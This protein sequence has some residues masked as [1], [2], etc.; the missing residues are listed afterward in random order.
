MQ[1]HIEEAQGPYGE[2]LDVEIVT[3]DSYFQIVILY[4]S[5]ILPFIS[6]SFNYC[7]HQLGCATDTDTDF[8]S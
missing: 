8:H 1:A 3:C 6:L 2:D 7:A 4:E 5:N